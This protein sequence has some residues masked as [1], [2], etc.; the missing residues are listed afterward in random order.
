MAALTAQNRKPIAL[1]NP[2]LKSKQQLSSKPVTTIATGVGHKLSSL[3]SGQLLSNT[4]RTLSS[5]NG[6]SAAEHSVTKGSPFSLSTKSGMPLTSKQLGTQSL[7]VMTT[8]SSIALSGSSTESPLL[9]NE[10]LALVSAPKSTTYLPKED[11]PLTHSRSVNKSTLIQ[12]KPLL[13][14]TLK[15][16]LKKEERPKTATTMLFKE[17]EKKER[18]STLS[19]TT[20]IQSPSNNKLLSSSLTSA[21]PKS[22][23]VSSKPST[24]IPAV[25][26]SLSKPLVSTT[27]KKTIKVTK[28]P[29]VTIQ[30]AKL[31]GNKT[32]QTS[33]T[34]SSHTTP[35]TLTS[36]QTNAQATKSSI[37]HVVPLTSTEEMPEYDFSGPPLPK[38]S[39]QPFITIGP[40]LDLTV[41]VETVPEMTKLK[42]SLVRSVAT[43]L[44]CS[45]DFFN[46]KDPTV[47]H[48]KKLGKSLAH[49]DPEFLLKVVLYTRCDL[50]IR[51]TANFLLALAASYPLCRPYLKK[52][53]SAS[54][55]LPSDWIEVAEIYQSFH[56]KS[57][58]FGSLP[59][60]LRKVMA[61]KFP[62]FDA[63]Q[64]AKY[65]KDSTKKKKQRKGK[66][67][68]KKKDTKAKTL[69]GG[70]R[71]K[72]SLETQESLKTS[73]ESDSDS[74]T[75]SSESE[76]EEE[77]E[78]LK[79]NLKQLIRKLHISEPVLHIMSL[80]GK[81]YPETP[82]EF[83][84]SGLPGTW[85]QDQAG[86]R[87]KL[88]TPET[89]ETQISLRG[90]KAFVW[91]ELIDHHKL[92]FMAMLRNLRNLIIAG[93]SKER[94]QWVINKLTDERAVIN[95]K[96]FPFRF[97]SAYEVLQQLENQQK[98]KPMPYPV[99]KGRKPV[100]PKKIKPIPDID[101]DLI[102]RY[103]NALDSSLKIATYH[104]VQ[105][106]SGTTIVL[107]NVGSTMKSPCSTAKGLGK[108][109]TVLEIGVLLAL[110]C[111]YTCENCSVCVYG[112]KN[113]KE[114]V[115]EEGTILHNMDTVLQLVSSQGLDLN[116]GAIPSEFLRTLIVDRVVV[117]NLILLTNEMNMES[118]DGKGM[119]NFLNKYRHLVNPNLLFVSVDLSCRSVGISSTITAS[120]ENDIHLAG[121]SDKILR[122]IAERSD[123]GQ[124]IYIERI[125]EAYNLKDIK[126]T[127]LLPTDSTNTQADSV[128]ISRPPIQWK[129]AR[130]FIS[131][132][133][134]DMHG[135]RDLLTR[136]VFPELRR[137][138]QR[139]HVYVY[140]L[141][142]RWGV[143]EEDTRHHKALE[144]C[145]SEVNRCH[146]FI[147][148][149][150]QRYGWSPE[151]YEVPDTSEYDWIR[152]YPK[153]RSITEL[154]I[155]HGVLCDPDKVA[156][157]AFFYFRDP[158][159]LDEIPSKHKHDFKSESNEAT[160]KIESLKSRIRV[161]GI[162][163]Y[164]NYPSHWMD[165]MQNKSMLGSLEDFGQR[166]LN[167]L[168]NAI[169]RDYPEQDES[170]DPLEQSS[171]LNYDFMNNEATKFIGRQAIHKE[172]IEAIHSINS[173]VVLVAGKAGSGKSA[174][175][176]S[177][178]QHLS[179][180]ATAIPYFVGTFPGSSTI[181]FLLSSVCW[182]AKHQFSLKKTIP[183]DYLELVKAWPQFLHDGLNTDTDDEEEKVIV[184]IDG[185]DLLDDQ[186]NGRSLD[187]L[188]LS[189]PHGVVVVLSAIEGGSCYSILKKREHPPYEVIV[190]S[191]D[192]ADK[193]Q[194]VRKKLAKYR[195]HLDESPFNNQMKLLLT[196]REASNPL[197]LYLACEELRLF[198]IYE[199]V[200][201][202]LKKLPATMS[203]LLHEILNRLEA[204]H[205][206]ELISAA[207]TLLCIVR[208]GLKEN[209][210][211]EI[212]ALIFSSASTKSKIPP[213]V[214]T[215]MI[216]SLQT[217]LHP[218][219]DEDSDML[220]L[221]HREIEKSVKSRYLRGAQADRERQLHK[222]IGQ[223]FYTLADPKGD[224]SFT[225]NNARAF[226][227]LP[228]HLLAA[229]DW[230]LLETVVCTLQFAIRKSQLGL[231]KSLLEDYTP[232]VSGLPP[233]KIREVSRFCQ[234]PKVTNFRDFVSRNLHI[235]TATP[236]LALQQ[237]VNEPKTS[238]VCQD[239][240]LLAEKSTSPLV[241][242]VNKPEQ[243]TSYNMLIPCHGDPALTTAISPDGRLLAA[244]FKSSIIRLYDLNSGKEIKTF[245]GHS[246]SIN[247][248]CF[249][250]Q[251]LICSASQDST[252]SLWNVDEGF[253][254]AIMKGHS[255]SVRCCTANKSGK[256]L[257]SVS[258]D[259]SIRVWNGTDGSFVAVLKSPGKSSQINCVSFHPE[260][261]LIA[262]GCWDSTLKIWDTFNKKK[263]KSLKGHATS[264]QA[265]SYL[266]TGQHIVSAA[267]DGEVRVW[268]AR[269]GITVGTINGHA[270]PINSL[271]FT[272]TG[273]FLF[274]ASSDKLV[275]VWSGTLG[276]P[277]PSLGIGGQH[278]HS[279]CLV[280]DAS[281]QVVTVGYHDGVV[282]KYNIQTGREIFA[283]KLHD[284]PIQSIAVQDEVHMTA[285]A[286][287]TIKL[288]T[289][290]S[291]PRTVVLDAH[292][293]PIMSATWTKQGLVSVG[294][295]LAIFVWPHD[296][297]KYSKMLKKTKANLE[298]IEPL[299]RLSGHT[300]QISKVAFSSDGIT[301]ATV[302]HD[303][304]IIIWDM[305]SKKSIKTIPNAHSDWINTCCFTSQSPELFITGSNDFN[306]KVWKTTDWTEKATLKGHT[307]PVTVL[308]YSEGCII[309]GATD[310]TVKVWT[311]KGIEVTT[312]NCH[313]QRVNDAIVYSLTGDG[314]IDAWADV[315][316]SLEPSKAQTKL[317][318]IG[319]L[320]ASD[321]GTV[322]VWKP[323]IPNEVGLLEGHS[324]RV[325]SV[326]CSLNNLSVTSSL[327]NT[328]RVWQPP[329]PE[330]GRLSTISRIKG[331]T[332]PISGMALLSTESTP[333]LLSATTGRDGCFIIWSVQV[334]DDENMELSLSQLFRVKASEKALSAVCLT[335]KLRVIVGT[336]AGDIE[337]W[338]FTEK[339][340]P[341]LDSKIA[342]GVVMGGAPIS[343]L[344]LTGDNKYLLASSWANQV[345]AIS[346]VSK[347][348]AIRM[349]GHKDWVMDAC[350]KESGK[351][352]LVYS[353]GLDKMLYEY[354]LKGPPHSAKG[355]KRT[356]AAAV[357]TT[358]GE[359][360]H[361]P[362][363]IKEER[364]D[365]WPLAV[366]AV[367]DDHVAITDSIGR[368]L[369]W[370]SQSKTF[371]LTKKIHQSEVTC[372]H[373]F[374]DFI[375]TG[376]K[377][378][379]VK[380]WKIT[381]GVEVCLKQ[382]GHFNCQSSATVLS[383]FTVCDKTHVLLVGDCN[384]QVT[385]LKWK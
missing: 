382:V 113:Y 187:W 177:L 216:R 228:Y 73:D 138:C 347:K 78:R 87:M 91:E 64:L 207:L 108:P 332:G 15:T 377:D 135:E 92:P 110:M 239:A 338:Q 184:L 65:N 185:I 375:V 1:S 38:T 88:P 183:T 206:V 344:M 99:Q 334:S 287:Q 70:Q 298:K 220:I 274:T 101:P 204:E 156:G 364:E 200:T 329:L 43:S 125:D 98:M 348:V 41:N 52:Y 223:F 174:F 259:M 74:S 331:H 354:S 217:F 142:L 307:S 160:E 143:T 363:A 4:H 355:T 63:Y 117:D 193:A 273:D 385:L 230:K 18:T 147:G 123:A 6:T 293:G 343:Q 197:Y 296:V 44:L 82:E 2:L 195:K 107:C 336:D 258:W 49:S 246:N 323:F 229:G 260:G 31:Q 152:E 326:S 225:G 231:A 241:Y 90:N 170:V 37:Q 144:I 192:M 208:N 56:D 266:T 14:S 214:F 40:E 159:V 254:V 60:A 346:V 321:D 270:E 218:L 300:A 215:R 190:A 380:I 121:Y 211:S 77:L 227:E 35:S 279:T 179:K 280:Y 304:S 284:A 168:W 314:T 292:I 146:Y 97:F 172:A 141:D 181:S 271:S 115:L 164:D 313:K 145:M 305:L 285:S 356:P 19:T 134:R 384:G 324:D 263:L 257:V 76:S 224:Y 253:R 118:R 94:H 310:G 333:N 126:T 319:V 178:A 327:D 33:L 59:T 148:I 50:N 349:E 189:L 261:Q 370:N 362:L 102:R 303:K 42:I 5:K 30:T 277:L 379:T 281:Q 249:V 53:F 24:I 55:R 7:T 210:L 244:G 161:S 328:I 62:D 27:I 276:C 199:E 233:A 111:K 283:E 378:M 133:F 240:M 299:T 158:A 129:T 124:M 169:Q 302:S 315:M 247:S 251:S 222:V 373:S 234:V 137:R 66:E 191:L 182:E 153:G 330:P 353:I 54:V 81:H 361:I 308:S 317:D 13:S 309:S 335:K 238:L 365:P 359:K 29:K 57:I 71:D 155:H 368:M 381:K 269:T 8:R 341:V 213:A 12:S 358:N 221:S 120:H 278:G 150:G 188:P 21:K 306:I 202:F 166:V 105:P 80:V 255:R 262:V 26:T 162:E 45:P 209:E 295:D 180:T 75:D 128:A 186:Y 86:K 95:S 114:V 131:S 103:R 119:I 237:A 219:H 203:G 149:L 374:S 109:K 46:K 342:A 205:G 252:L 236:S 194:I 286:D 264:I 9:T 25:T 176:A 248:I 171:E 351:Q 376:S 85:D 371:V 48:F 272:P 383:T 104:N 290:T 357:M 243:N 23:G 69:V 11:I 39:D 51:T 325:L 340:Y 154:E 132:P 100:R 311:R 32:L 106:I 345:V 84:T 173:G 318:E 232:A 79:F 116:P 22:L 36:S 139:L 16:T 212:L 366:C 294:E 167:N 312:L 282:C 112:D 157:K 268:S 367:L 61:K 322:G 20:S 165:V 196:K 226:S 96:Q 28:T 67:D 369:L 350:T 151:N 256:T 136:Y 93:I 47:K 127:A 337:I 316:D 242:W 289:P 352:S 297:N 72:G 122:F 10:R 245:I 17:K 275:K 360:Y 235:L 320:T 58:N 68:E 267:L 34:K 163:V 3:T 89:W 288:W 372:I 201:S 175:M 130:V 140:E 265:C 301:M 250:T 83:R 198:G 339:I 291:L